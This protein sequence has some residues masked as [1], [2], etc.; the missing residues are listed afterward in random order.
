MKKLVIVILILSG[1]F[2]CNTRNESLPVEKESEPIDL[3]IVTQSYLDAPPNVDIYEYQKEQFRKQYAQYEFDKIYNEV[4]KDERMIKFMEFN[5]STAARSSGTLS[6]TDDLGL[7]STMV[8]YLDQM[9][10]L[11]PEEQETEID[12]PLV[13]RGLETIKSEIIA[14]INLST[15][16]RE[17][18]LVSADMYIQNLAGII[19]IIESENSDSSGRVAG[20]L[21]RLIRSV[22]SVVATVVVGVVVGAL[23]GLAIGGAPG[24]AV[25]AF[26]GGVSGVIIGIELTLADRCYA[27]FT[28]SSQWQ[29]CSTGLC[30]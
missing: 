29:A 24:V 10:A 20:W 7:S 28:C 11:I 12:I 16:D 9:T 22:V 8:S 3:S 18:L 21:S 5:S 4:M 1:A 2:S 27:P 30:L 19:T 17:A 6:L 23:A 14:N 26:W 13:Q 25:G 15:E